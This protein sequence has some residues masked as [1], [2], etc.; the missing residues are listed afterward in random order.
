MQL[1]D[2]ASARVTAASSLLA[3]SFFMAIPWKS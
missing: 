2:G 3:V 1:I